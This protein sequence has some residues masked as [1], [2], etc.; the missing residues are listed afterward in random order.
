M[1]VLISGQPKSGTTALFHS[2]KNG[3]GD[4]TVTFFEGAY[5]Y[6]KAAAVE[7]GKLLAKVLLNIHAIDIAARDVGLFDRHVLIVRDPRD[8]IISRFLYLMYHLSFV[9]DLDKRAVYLDAVRQKEQD[10]GS[11]SLMSLYRLQQQLEGKDPDELKG[12]MQR[13]FQRVILLADTFPEF[14][15]LNYEDFVDAKLDALSG[16]LGFGVEPAEVAAQYSRV[17]RTKSYGDWKNWFTEEDREELLDTTQP[18]MDRFGYA[19]W[20]LNE[21]PRIDPRT[22]SDYILKLIDSRKSS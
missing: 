21:P 9:D 18:F 5:S 11:V 10:P 6:E 19:D 7:S 13:S 4:G 8:Q 22:G 17:A 1:K 3:M 2:I 16:F 20:S 15:V 14:F 12:F